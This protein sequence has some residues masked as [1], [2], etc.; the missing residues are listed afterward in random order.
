MSLGSVVATVLW[1]IGSAGFSLYVSNFGSYGETY[2]ALA[3]VVVLLLWLFLTSFI[4]LLGAE[5]N[6]ETEHQTNR[7]STAGPEKPMGE[8]DAVKAD[9]TP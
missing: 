9:T 5:I 2:G 7:D 4:V 1:L 8:R 6:S 3:G